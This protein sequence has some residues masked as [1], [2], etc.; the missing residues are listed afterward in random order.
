MRKL[1][2]AASNRLTACPP[3]PLP[4]VPPVPLSSCP[5][6]LSCPP[7]LLSSCPPTDSDGLCGARASRRPPGPHPV[8]GGLRGDLEVP[9]PPVP[10]RRP[11]LR[12]PG[13]PALRLL[14]RRGLEEGRLLAA[15]QPGRHVR[16]STSALIRDYIC[17][18]HA[19]AYRHVLVFQ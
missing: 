11:P 7:V 9:G 2:C 4:S 13:V 3:V 16:C 10:A 8:L 5:V 17:S 1:N 15:R 12:G 19:K 6:L 14:P 18:L